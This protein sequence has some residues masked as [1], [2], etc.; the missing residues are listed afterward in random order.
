[1]PVVHAPTP[2]PTYAPAYPTPTYPTPVAQAPVAPQPVAQPVPAPVAQA[3]VAQAPVA[4]APVAQAPVAHAPVVEAPAAPVEAPTTGAPVD[5][6]ALLLQVVS[7]KTGYPPDMLE[8]S[9]AL[10]ADLGIDSIKRVEILAAIMKMRPDLP[11]VDTKAMAALNTLGEIVSY[12][13][14]HLGAPNASS[15]TETARPKAGSAATP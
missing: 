2:A 15:G 7:D 4:Q 5:A 9:M 1:M 12:I 13:N 10:E 14:N 8:M 6:E 11:K 3:P